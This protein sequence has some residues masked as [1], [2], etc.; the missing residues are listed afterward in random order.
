MSCSQDSVPLARPGT[1]KVL[2]TELTGSSQMN[3]TSAAYED[4]DML[5]ELYLSP[6]KLVLYVAYTSVSDLSQA[7]MLENL[8]LLDLEGNAV[9]D[10]VQ[11][12][13][14][15]LC[16]QLRT[17]TLKGNP[18]C[19]RPH[20]NTTQSEEEEGYSYWLAVRELVPQLQY[21]DDMCAEE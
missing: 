9:D 21:L 6:E 17:L 10:L 1:E 5:V 7:S 15:G 12:Q 16:S 4:S 14:L 3:S 11:V 20:P 19:M 8:Q 13:Y 18:V 2:V